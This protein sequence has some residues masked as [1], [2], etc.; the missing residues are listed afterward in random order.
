MRS[1]V[2]IPLIKA[3]QGAVIASDINNLTKVK[4]T[5]DKIKQ[6]MRRMTTKITKQ[7]VMWITLAK[8]KS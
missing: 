8:E 4:V 7:P 2:T 5:N 6:P 1:T 3:A